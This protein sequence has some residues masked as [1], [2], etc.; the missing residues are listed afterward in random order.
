[1]ALLEHATVE[2]ALRWLRERGVRWMPGDTANMAIGQG[3]VLVTPL[4]MACFVASVA[5]GEIHTKPTLLHR[6][7]QLQHSEPIGLSPAQRAALAKRFPTL[8]IEGLRAAPV[9][10]LWEFSIGL[11]VYYTSIDARYL[12]RGD[13]IDLAGDR[14]LSEQ[15]RAE[16]RRGQLSKAAES[17]MIVF[18]PPRASYTVT[19]FTD[20]DCTYCRRLHQEIGEL[21]R[22]MHTQGS[23]HDPPDPGPPRHPEPPPESSPPP[24]L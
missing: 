13:V 19:V 6:P 1:M 18:A 24:V 2:G 10:G 15:R 12:V 16:L 4:Q 8:R 9:A 5:R 17:D 7:G 22:R 21:N 14:N 23:L 3:D 11:D 20:I